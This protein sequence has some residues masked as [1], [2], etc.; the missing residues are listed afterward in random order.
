MIGSMMMLLMLIGAG[1]EQFSPPGHILCA[2]PE[3]SVESG[4]NSPLDAKA[5]FDSLN[6]RWVGAWS[7]G[8]NCYAVS[9]DEERDIVFMGAGGGIYALDATEPSNLAKLSEMSTRGFVEGL[10]YDSTTQRLYAAAHKGGLEI[11]DV[12]DLSSPQRLSSYFTPDPNPTF[13]VYVVGSYAYVADGWS[14]LR[15]IDVSD[16]ANPYEVGCWDANGS[17]DI[18]V[19][20]VYVVDSYAYIAAAD[21]GL[22]VIDVS[23]PSNPYEVGYYPVSQAYGVHVSGSYAYLAYGGGLKVID[24]SDPLNLHE[25]GSINFPLAH[26]VYVSGSYAFVGSRSSDLLRIIDVSDPANP[27]TV[28]CFSGLFTYDIYVSGSRPYAYFAADRSGLKV[29]DIS[30]LPD[31]VHEV[32]N[33]TRPIVPGEM[34]NLFIVADSYAYVVDGDLRVIDVND[35]LSTREISRLDFPG[36][37][38][39][40]FLYVSDYAYVGDIYFSTIY[41]V[42]VSD[43]ANPSIVGQCDAYTSGSY[44]LYLSW[45]YLYVAAGSA[46]GGRGGLHM[47]DVSDP[48]NPREVGSYSQPNVV[49]VFASGSYA[50]VAGENTFHVIDVSDTANLHEVG[51]CQL[52]SSRWVEDMYVS[53]SYA[54]VTLGFDGLK[55][56][57]ISNPTNPHIIGSLNLFY[58]YGVHGSGSYVFVTNGGRATGEPPGFNVIDVSDPTNPQMVGYYEPPL[59]NTAMRIYATDSY[60][61]VITGQDQQGLHDGLTGFQIYEFVPPFIDESDAHGSS[62]FN[63]KVKAQWN[64]LSFSLPTESDVQI[65]LYSITG[66]LLWTKEG[67]FASGQ[68]TIS[69]DDLLPN[70]VYLAVVK[71][72]GFSPKISKIAVIR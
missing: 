53:G 18:Y 20:D 4:G 66:R 2:E 12:S 65:K 34:E 44:D 42:D 51:S 22:C 71:A 30:Y 72:E 15:V 69:F 56:V 64:K 24:V 13:N 61:Y 8:P 41:I 70:G 60:A 52:S 7:F 36:Y 21:S 67:H 37:F 23:D 49:T 29:I 10:F 57:D 26:E 16:P 68:H 14:G 11:W 48:M 54:Y 28:A 39:A 50:Y 55:V 31:S 1:T 33:Y 40:M 35:P 58:A 47:I 27:E 25:V 19:Y 6:V 17:F 59:R 43:P 38:S 63:L 62:A 45:P 32:G 3:A 9:V 46:A 5:G